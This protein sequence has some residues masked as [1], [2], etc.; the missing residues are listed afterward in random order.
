MKELLETCVGVGVR[1]A[2]SETGHD[3]DRIDDEP[4][5]VENEEAR[6]IHQADRRLLHVGQD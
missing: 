5:D 1:K 3:V 2:H 6:S 4:T